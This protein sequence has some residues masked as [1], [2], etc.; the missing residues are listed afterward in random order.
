[1]RL[2]VVVSSDVL[3]ELARGLRGQGIS[4]FLVVAAATDST[5]DT[6]QAA[7]ADERDS[8]TRACTYGLLGLRAM[9]F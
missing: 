9:D 4:G 2:F 5:G 1:M 3:Q 6:K 7:K 8:V